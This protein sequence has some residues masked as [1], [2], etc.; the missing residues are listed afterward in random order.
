[1]S[2]QWRVRQL[3]TLAFLKLMRYRQPMELLEKS[4]FYMKWAGEN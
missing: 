1:M 3:V 2:I 4:K